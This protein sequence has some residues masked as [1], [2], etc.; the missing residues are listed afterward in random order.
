LTDPLNV[1]NPA[2]R[3]RRLGQPRFTPLRQWLCGIAIAIAAVLVAAH[4]TRPDPIDRLVADYSK[5]Q[6]F[7]E[8]GMSR[9]IELPA[10]AAPEAVIKEAL[11]INDSDKEGLASLKILEIRRVQIKDAQEDSYTAALVN[12]PGGKKIVLFSYAGNSG[13]WSRILDP[14]RTNDYTIPVFTP[15]I[16]QYQ[17]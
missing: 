2:N 14:N 15:K 9:P 5:S 7:F 16:G 11:G 4:F 6:G 8:N 12:T 3:K 1:V 13:W 10:G 17:Q